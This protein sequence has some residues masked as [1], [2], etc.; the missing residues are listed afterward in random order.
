MRNQTNIQILYEDN[1][2]IV[3]LK[4]RNI[5]SQ[6]DNTGDKDMLTLIKEYI[7]VSANK[8]GNVYTALVH[9]LDR[10]TGGVMVFAK[11]S[12]AASRL[13]EQLQNN[14]I[15]KKYLAIAVGNIKQQY[16]QLTHYLVKDA[17]NNIV[18]AHTVNLENSK[19]AILDYKVLEIKTE[20]GIEEADYFDKSDSFALG[21]DFKSLS[22]S[23]IEVSLI[24]G[25]S[26]QIRAQM[27]AIGYPLYA[28]HKYQ[29]FKDIV[30]YG[31]PLALWAYHLKFTH[32]VKGDIL[33]FRIAPPEEEKYWKLF[34]VDKY[35][36]ISKPN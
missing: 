18:K 24:T 7:A 28:D 11:T 5:P 3:V 9:R 29:N 1:H 23:L 27:S 19:K 36:N 15:E 4:L 6:A 32:P 2:I 14:K 8:Q 20:Q 31:K 13:S 16:A 26:H 10:P 21:K 33:Q 25:R 30:G 17:K 22:L 35:V 12:K 34:N